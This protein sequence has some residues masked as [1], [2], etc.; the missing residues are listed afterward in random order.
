MIG[1]KCLTSDKKYFKK[2]NYIK[3]LISYNH[4]P[5]VLLEYPYPKDSQEYFWFIDHLK[6]FSHDNHDEIKIT[7]LDE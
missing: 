3:L 6:E 4:M 5:K 7:E 2:N 1:H